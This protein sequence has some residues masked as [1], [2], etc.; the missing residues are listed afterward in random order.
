MPFL[1]PRS[2]SRSTSNP[3]SRSAAALLSPVLL[4]LL[5]GSALQLQQAALFDSPL[6]AGMLAT[7][8]AL[9]ALLVSLAFL[10][11]RA[12]VLVS[13]A[14]ALLLASAASFGL[15]G[16]RASA[17]AGAAL[18]PAL[19]GQDIV[20]TGQIAAMPQFGEDGVRFRLD[21]ISALQIGRAHV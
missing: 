10:R 12:G 2:P 18:S 14:L 20:V 15:T 13:C 5:A 7:S 17:F 21:V 9:L 4:G 11:Q 8:M 3:S 19:E 1:S 16:L 6:Y